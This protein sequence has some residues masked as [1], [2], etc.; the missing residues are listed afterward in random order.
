VRGVGILIEAEWK[1]SA[2]ISESRK[3]L[4]SL[5]RGYLGNL[6]KPVVSEHW[7]KDKSKNVT[8]IGK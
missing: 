5:G 1:S 2:G 4:A 3:R 8:E 6:Q 7:P